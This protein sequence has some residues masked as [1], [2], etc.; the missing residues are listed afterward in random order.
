[1]LPPWEGNKAEDKGRTT[2]FCV[3]R[4][5]VAGIMWW[6]FDDR[7]FFL[8]M[9]NLG[10]KQHFAKTRVF[11]QTQLQAS[12]GISWQGG[13]E[14]STEQEVSGET[15]KATKPFNAA[16]PSNISCPKNKG[17]LRWGS[18]K[19]QCWELHPGWEREV[20]CLTPL[21][22]LWLMPYYLL[23]ILMLLLLCFKKE[24]NYFYLNYINING[25]KICFLK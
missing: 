15:D 7:V 9:T 25:S 24:N 5:I 23:A 2:D 16:L 12:P 20:K 22:G 10:S 6:L 11:L 4:T 21:F 3:W 8:L 18:S 1:M 14:A 19:C 17:Q 13:K